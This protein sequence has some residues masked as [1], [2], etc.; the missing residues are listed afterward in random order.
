MLTRLKL[1]AI[2]DQL[3]ALLDEA[4]RRQMSLREKECR[5]FRVR[6][7]TMETEEAS[8]GTKETPGYCRSAAGSVAGW[9]GREGGV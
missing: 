7:I 3:D 4:A 8:Y 2:R 1:T 9:G 6:A 5:E